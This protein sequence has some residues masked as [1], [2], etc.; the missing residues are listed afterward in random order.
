MTP[1]ELKK[2]KEEKKAK[3]L[4]DKAG[5]VALAKYHDAESKR[6]QKAADNCDVFELAHRPPTGSFGGSVTLVESPWVGVSWAHGH[7]L[8]GRRLSTGARTVT[9]ITLELQITRS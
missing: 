9:R 3:L 2:Q 1:E 7:F 5:Y 6:F 8:R 4:A